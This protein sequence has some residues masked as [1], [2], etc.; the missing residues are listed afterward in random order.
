MVLS[1]L[2]SRSSSCVP[3]WNWV[4]FSCKG[5]I[6]ILHYLSRFSKAVLLNCFRW[7]PHELT[8]PTRRGRPREVYAPIW[9]QHSFITASSHSWSAP[10]SSSSSAC[11]ARRPRL[12][13][14]FAA[15]MRQRV[16]GRSDSVSSN[17]RRISRSCGTRSATQFQWAWKRSRRRYSHQPSLIIFAVR[18]CSRLWLSGWRMDR[19]EKGR[20]WMRTLYMMMSSTLVR[21][22]H[23]YIMYRITLRLL[24]GYIFDRGFYS[25]LL[26]AT[27]R[28]D[29]YRMFRELDLKSSTWWSHWSISSLHRFA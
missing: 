24:F 2:D 19:G 13:E 29:F 11:C 3:E 25:S 22:Y 7:S 21:V 9:T 16:S 1:G 5:F 27:G 28:P 10:S 14:A 17:N 15:T 20:I 6:G 12:T 4:P 8:T 23:Y 26:I 18:R